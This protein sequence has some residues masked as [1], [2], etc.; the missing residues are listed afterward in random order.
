MADFPFEFSRLSSRRMP[1]T[2]PTA[3]GQ[4][5]VVNRPNPN[6]GMDLFQSGTGSDGGYRD[7]NPFK[8]KNLRDPLG[9]NTRTRGMARRQAYEDATRDINRLSGFSTVAADPQWEGL[10]Q[11]LFEKTGDASVG[12]PRRIRTTKAGP[13]NE[14]LTL[15]DVTDTSG[16]PGDQW[17]ST[18]SG[19]Y[20]NKPYKGYET[21]DEYMNR[22]AGGPLAALQSI[23][24]ESH[25]DFMNRQTKSYDDSLRALRQQAGADP[26]TGLR[27]VRR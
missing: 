1:S 9:L 7:V 22:I 24:Y 8:G 5:E 14:Y 13:G 12:D 11:A 23:G 10:K 18:R 16:W 20:S 25:D 6:S 27:R 26:L 19:S 2:R 17:R 21:H 4:H 3:Q 15:S